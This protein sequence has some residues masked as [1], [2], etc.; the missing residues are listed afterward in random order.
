MPLLLCSRRRLNRP[1]AN[2]KVCCEH[3][4]AKKKPENCL[5]T[6]HAPPIILTSAPSIVVIELAPPSSQSA[7]PSQ[8]FPIS[9]SPSN[10]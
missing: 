2:Q 8:A 10:I 5:Q 7:H 1:T 6:A 9:R 4:T 3:K